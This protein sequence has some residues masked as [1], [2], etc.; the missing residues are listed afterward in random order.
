MRHVILPALEKGLHVVCD[1]FADS[2][3]AYQGYGRGFPVDE[4]LAI[5]RFAIN[6]AN[7]DLTI[8]LDVD[9]DLGFE[10]LR[11]RHKAN[12]STWDRIEREEQAFHQRVREGYLALARRWPERF[13]V[14]DARGDPDAVEAEVWKAVQRVLDGQ[15]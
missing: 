13:R 7:P 10:R 15:P 1:R 9:V 14:V 5:N 3:T 4:M 6:G 12:A 2:T 8:L 11:E